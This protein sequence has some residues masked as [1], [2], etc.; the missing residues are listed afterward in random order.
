MKSLNKLAH[1]DSL[2]QNSSV[3][4]TASM[5][6]TGKGDDGTTKTFGCDQR[7][8][9]SSAIAEALGAVDEINSLL[10]VVKTRGEKIVA[11][12]GLSFYAVLADVQQDLFVAQAELAGAEKKMGKMRVEK[13][14]GWVNAIEKELP[15]ITTF[16]VSGG[17]ELG[18]LCD[19]ARTIAR[20][21]ERRVV[22]ALE[23]A[24]GV[25]SALPARSKSDEG[26]GGDS[27]GSHKELLAYMNRLSSLLYALARL[28]NH[29]AGVTEEKPHYDLTRSRRATVN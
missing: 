9:K 20:R 18:A 26:G 14:E 17:T 16:F 25:S 2:V 11:I 4:Y 6:F 19:H 5:L 29:R 21:A 10:G 7:V 8:S 22:K 28:A 12:D 13:L 1:I 15:P 27:S 24:R 23:N 3:A